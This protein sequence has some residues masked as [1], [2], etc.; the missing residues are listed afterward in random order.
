MGSP[1]RT[2]SSARGYTLLE[3]IMVLMI[4]VLMWGM[5]AP[6]YT[7]AICRYRAESAARRLAADF[8]LARS[9]AVQTSGNVV[10]TFNT[11]SNTYTINGI[12]S[13]DRTSANY[14][15]NLAAEPYR[16]TLVTVP[17]TSSQVTFSTYGSADQSGTVTIQVNDVQWT[18][19]LEAT[20][21][22]VT[23]SGP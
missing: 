20:A 11:T 9:Q 18:V 2:S 1:I 6:R 17:F 7:A 22:K 15:V 16:A 3:V 12:T 19:T 21:G 10:V 23:V 5:A 4:M 13:F 8:A 14:T